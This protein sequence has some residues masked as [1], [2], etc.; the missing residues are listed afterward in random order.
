M[1]AGLCAQEVK[2]RGAPSAAAKA[3]ERLSALAAVTS[4]PTGGGHVPASR[5]WMSASAFDDFIARVFGRAATA[6]S[7]CPSE[8]D[9]ALPGK[10]VGACPFW[11]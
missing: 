6:T 1:V 9:E 2:R 10:A 4:S 8:N 11:K 5:F 7:C 3:F